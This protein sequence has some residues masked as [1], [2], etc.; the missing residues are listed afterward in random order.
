MTTTTTQPLFPVSPSR[1]I[2]GFTTS[3][4]LSLPNVVHVALDDKALG[5]H[6]VWSRTS[7]DVVVPP[8]SA[9][10]PE[11]LRHEAWLAE[12]PS[13]SINPGNK[14]APAGGFGFYVH[15]PKEFHDSL[16]NEKP[17]EV[18]MA[19]EVMFEGGWEWALGGKLPGICMP[20]TFLRLHPH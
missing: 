12:F 20:Y 14:T 13:G 19:Y 11:D 8:P 1:I 7:H 3:P 9:A 18:V 6:K 4:D 15:G 10:N 16:K 5:V 17:S 2:T